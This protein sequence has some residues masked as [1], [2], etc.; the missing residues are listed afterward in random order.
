MSENTNVS[1]PEQEPLEAEK[2]AIA[3]IP[4]AAADIRGSATAN[5]S[6]TASTIADQ[7]SVPVSV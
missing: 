5:A 4:S 3:V 1:A 7:R 2:P 6:M